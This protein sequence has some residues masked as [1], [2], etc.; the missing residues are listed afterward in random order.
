MMDA[1]GTASGSDRT[2]TPGLTIP[3]ANQSLKQARLDGEPE[4]VCAALVQLAQLH[5]RQGRYSQAQKLLKEVSQ[6]APP[7]S[8]SRCDAYRIL[9]N[10]AAEL[11][12]IDRAEACYHQAVDLARQLDDRFTLYK[13]Q[14]SLATN[15]YWQRGQFDLVLAA[16]EEA[17]SQ[18]LSLGLQDD[19]WFPLSDIA[20]CYWVTGQFELA[21]RAADQMEQAVN[22]G[23]LG[24]GFYCCLRAGLAQPGS[25]YLDMVLPLYQTARS[26]AEINGDPGLNTEVRLG[27]CRAYRQSGNLPAAA[28]W[29]EDAVAVTLRLNYRQFQAAAYN[30]RA[31]TALDASNLDQALNDLQSSIALS[32]QLHA[33][34][35]LTRSY[36]YLA[37]LFF[38]RRNPEAVSAWQKT[39][40]LVQDYGYGFLLQQERALVLPLIAA[41]LD[42]PAHGQ[43]QASRALYDQFLRA[44]PL[45]VRAWL[46]GQYTVWVGADCVSKDA[47]RQRRAGELLALLLA[48]PRRQL[49]FQQVAEAM[50][51]EKPPEAALDFYHHA[52]SALRRL[53]EPDLP[54]RRFI[55]QYLE[56]DDEEIRLH[57]PP[58]S[59]VDFEEFEA[60]CRRQVWKQAIEVYTGELLPTLRYA[61]WT[62][63]L[64]QHLA[65][66]Y[67]QALVG[68]AGQRLQDGFPAECLGLARQVLLI[69]AWNE[70]A[71]VL[72]M[73]AALQLGDRASAIRLFLRL[74]KVLQK[75][76]GIAPQK[77]LLDLF[78]QAQRR[79]PKT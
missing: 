8:P 11:G 41:G 22:P 54:D 71:A 25:G 36:L 50:C 9:G 64:R 13:C 72:G 5:F 10:C 45:P 1:D 65:D 57:L 70:Q 42:S 47:L 34:F 7:D 4:R 31:R 74:E 73:H 75:E 14:H 51:P 19:L 33:S 60:S 16:G 38:T 12:E 26:I 17:L 44:A 49:T 18:A 24:Y 63:P 76:L 53:L 32:N 48:S 40:H 56:V 27:L 58:G 61:E 15:I 21:A 2:E 69:N 6:T 29:A 55:C 67:E 20:W 43:A 62:I 39:A 66:L 77:E 68:L 3:R 37:A 23:S 78:S 28:A 59:R 30:E 35:D 46:L 79:L 52:I